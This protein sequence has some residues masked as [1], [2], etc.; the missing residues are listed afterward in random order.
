MSIYIEFPA[1]DLFM[2]I[3]ESGG[4]AIYHSKSGLIPDSHL[5]TCPVFQTSSGS[6]TKLQLCG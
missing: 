3:F 4:F 2:W 5:C 6:G 1:G